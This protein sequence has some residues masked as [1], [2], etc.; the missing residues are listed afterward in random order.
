MEKLPEQM[1]EREALV[2]MFDTFGG[3]DP[4][5]YLPYEKQVLTAVK[6]VLDQAVGQEPKGNE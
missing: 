2:L 3:N 5:S 4:R 6:K 1:S